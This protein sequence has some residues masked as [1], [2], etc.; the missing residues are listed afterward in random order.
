MEIYYTKWQLQPSTEGPQKLW[1]ELKQNGKQAQ[2]VGCF[3]VFFLIPADLNAWANQLPRSARDQSTIKPQNQPLK[4]S[5]ATHS[6]S[7]FYIRSHKELDSSVKMKCPPIE[8]SHNTLFICIN[9]VFITIITQCIFSFTRDFFTVVWKMHFFSWL[10]S[11]LF[12]LT[13][14]KFRGL[15]LGDPIHFQLCSWDQPNHGSKWKK[16]RAIDFTAADCRPLTSQ[17][18][19]SLVKMAVSKPPFSSTTPTCFYPIILWFKP[20][21]PSL[22][23][24]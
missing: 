21:K 14:H 18:G 24:I 1:R 7:I 5:F 20:S 22:A 4:S 8:C 2:P 12:C 16:R 9:K 17:A 23:H 11:A 15:L 6:C 10:N 13:Q 3:F 19:T